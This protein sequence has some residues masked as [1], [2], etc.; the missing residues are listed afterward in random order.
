VAAVAGTAIQASR[1]QSSTAGAA[2]LHLLGPTNSEIEGLATAPVLVEEYGDYQCPACGL[3]HA[4]TGP[5][6]NQLV[7]AGTIRFAFHPFAFIGPESVSAAAAAECVADSGNYFAMWDVLYNNQFP[8]NSGALTTDRLVAFAQQAGVTNPATLQ[9]IRSGMYKGWVQ[10]VTQQGSQRGV[11]STPTVFVNGQ[12]LAD[13][14]PRG[15]LAAVNAAMNG[16]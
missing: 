10:K 5:T 4:Q 7:K 14:S 9:C 1:A 12:A 2:P 11:N 15:L 8:E 6:I 3:L 16:K 13:R